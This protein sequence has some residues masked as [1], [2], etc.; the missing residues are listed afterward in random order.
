MLTNKTHIDSISNMIYRMDQICRD[1]FKKTHI[2]S[3][4]DYVSSLLNFIRYPFGPFHHLS[5]A[6]SQTLNGSLE[7][8]LGADGIIIFKKSNNYKIGIFEAKI[9]KTRWD[10]TVG[11]RAGTSRFQRQIENQRKINPEIAVWEMFFNNNHSQ[12]QFDKIGSTCVKRDIALSYKKSSKLWKFQDLEK[13]T[14]DS[15]FSNSNVPINLEQIIQEILSCKF[16]QIL[17]YKSEGIQFYA[18][19]NEIRIPLIRTQLSDNNI[20]I[21]EYKAIDKFL[22][23]SDLFSYTHIDLDSYEINNN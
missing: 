6:H 20:R 17:N 3:E 9:I 16:G 7:Q 22:K 14:M 11:R 4:R 10:S 23:N 5:L 18:D 19:S 15:Y 21:E 12:V 13:L 8:R 1:D 2:V